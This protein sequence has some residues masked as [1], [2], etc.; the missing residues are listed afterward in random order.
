M[1]FF[2]VEHHCFPLHEPICAAAPAVCRQV[3]GI[4]WEFAGSVFR[5]G[6]QTQPRKNAARILL[7]SSWILTILISTIYCANLMA[8][9]TEVTDTSAISSIND[10]VDSNYSTGMLNSGTPYDVLRVNRNV[11]LQSRKSYVIVVLSIHTSSRL[12]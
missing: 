2:L 8:A 10:L 1:L 5:Q 12:P 7:A 3:A 6:F 11:S 4:A 9:L